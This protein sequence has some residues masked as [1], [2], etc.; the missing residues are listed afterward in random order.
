MCAHFSRGLKFD[1]LSYH[2]CDAHL[3]IFCTNSRMWHH[4]RSCNWINKQIKFIYS[5]NSH[6]INNNQIWNQG[7]NKREKKKMRGNKLNPVCLQF[8]GVSVMFESVCCMENLP[9]Y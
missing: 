2:A 9:I 6:H 4:T 7:A 8:K 3:F 5:Q 1:I